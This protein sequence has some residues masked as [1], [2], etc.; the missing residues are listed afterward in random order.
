MQLEGLQGGD[1]GKSEGYEL[2]RE[3]R[4][5]ATLGSS[6]GRAF[7]C[8][9]KCPLERCNRNVPSSI[10]GRESGIFSKFRE[11]CEVFY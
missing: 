4:C 2:V 10:L 11:I 8:S 3:W 5:E 1:C 7:D 9:L 6:V